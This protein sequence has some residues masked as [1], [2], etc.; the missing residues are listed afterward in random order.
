MLGLLR[1]VE[2]FDPDRGLR[3]TTY[4]THW[5]RAHTHR[6]KTKQLDQESP[7]ISDAVLGKNESIFGTREDGSQF[8]RRL[9]SYS[10]DVMSVDANG[11]ESGESTLRLPDAGVA[12]AEQTV[13]KQRDAKVR[14]I[15]VDIAGEAEEHVLKHR[16]ALW[17][18]VIFDRLL[19]DEPL[20]LEQLGKQHRLS[21]EGIRLMEKRI[22]KL[23][24]KRLLLAVD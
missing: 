11:D 6:Y 1:A 12:L 23:A 14:E 18:S 2:T 7:P 20:T 9:D 4:A 3:F 22:L 13:Q 19:S 8:R 21:R 5:I 17:V 15:L 24:K 16:T 10:L